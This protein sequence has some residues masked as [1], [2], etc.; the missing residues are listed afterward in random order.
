MVLRTIG[1]FLAGRK[2]KTDL[3]VTRE[4]ACVLIGAI[5]EKS[6]LDGIY[7]HGHVYGIRYHLEPVMPAEAAK[8][9]REHFHGRPGESV[10]IRYQV[11]SGRER[12]KHYFN[13]HADLL[14]KFTVQGAA[15]IP[16]RAL[17][18]EYLVRVD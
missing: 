9:A 8:F 16:A 2:Q 7:I 10:S 18:L 14:Y 17:T 12:E 6:L 13:F 15:V 1:N 11:F 4:A 3:P 5:T